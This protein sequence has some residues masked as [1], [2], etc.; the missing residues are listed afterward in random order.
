[1]SFDSPAV[2]LIFTKINLNYDNFQLFI[3]HNLSSARR[4]KYTS[5]KPRQC[6]EQNV[7]NIAK[8]KF[9][10]F[11]L[12]A[13]ARSKRLEPFDLYDNARPNIMRHLL[14]LYPHYR[15]KKCLGIFPY[16]LSS[17]GSV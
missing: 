2:D 17:S 4:H 8:E 11:L 5:K 7:S 1:M 15:V 10:K 9:R 6:N 14:A 12:Q 13:G 3:F 16:I